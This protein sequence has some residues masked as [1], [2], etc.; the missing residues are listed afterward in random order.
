VAYQADLHDDDP[1]WT[2]PRVFFAGA[3][4]GIVLGYFALAADPGAAPG[5][6][7]LTFFG[8]VAASAGNFL[9]VEVLTPVR[10]AHLCRRVR[11]GQVTRSPP[12]SELLTNLRLPR[13][14]SARPPAPRP[15]TWRSSGKS[16]S[17]VAAST[18]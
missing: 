3:L 12:M 4:P 17:A 1:R 18:S 14:N 9:A 13:F 15:M 10:R 7:Y 8:Y 6:V 16:S 2:A 5:R 11:T